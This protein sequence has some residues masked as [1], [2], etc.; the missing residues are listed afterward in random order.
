[1]RVLL[2]I[3][4][5][6]LLFPIDLF[7]V[8]G[9]YVSGSDLM[10]AV[11]FYFFIIKFFKTRELEIKNGTIKNTLSFPIFALIILAIASYAVNLS[12]VDMHYSLT[13]FIKWLASW[14]LF[15]IV[16]DSFRNT[17]ASELPRLKKIILFISIFVV[18]LSAINTLFPLETAKIFKSIFSEEKLADFADKGVKRYYI[19]L[20]GPNRFAAFLILPFFISLSSLLVGKEKPS[21]KPFYIALVVLFGLLLILTYSRSA[22]GASMIGFVVIMYFMRLSKKILF[23]A[24]SLAFIL[25]LFFSRIS[26]LMPYAEG[27]IYISYAPIALHGESM[28]SYLYNNIFG[29]FYIFDLAFKQFLQSPLFGKG[30]GSILK[31]DIIDFGHAHN[32]YLTALYNLGI[33]GFAAFMVILMRIFK[34]INLK[35]KEMKHFDEAKGFL[36]AF[37][38]WFFSLLAMSIFESVLFKFP[39]L[40]ALLMFV[41]AIILN[42]S[43]GNNLNGSSPSWDIGLNEQKVRSGI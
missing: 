35:I 15:F 40:I 8:W 38:A 2:Y 12:R 22:I 30:F 21:I 4:L 26:L 31:G 20:W 10:F 27:R 3:Y 13:T 42:L 41:M 32:A 18:L 1:M 25:F 37:Y 5:F 28:Q 9:F 6:T 19:P 34:I 33:F 7:P 23:I 17:T 24:V 36:I 39:F 11:V 43:P 14:L 29:R 16:L